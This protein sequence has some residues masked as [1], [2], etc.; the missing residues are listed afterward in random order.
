MLNMCLNYAHT[1]LETHEPYLL[2]SPSITVPPTQLKFTALCFAFLNFTLSC[3][4][5]SLYFTHLFSEPSNSHFLYLKLLPV[6]FTFLLLKQIWGLPPI[7]IIPKVHAVR[8]LLASSGFSDD[9][10]EECAE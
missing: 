5:T 8:A 7:W 3:K 9:W 4:V 2:H 6:L 10:T 1:T